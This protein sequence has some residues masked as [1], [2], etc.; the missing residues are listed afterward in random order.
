MKF[1]KKIW[2]KFRG[3]FIKRPPSTGKIISEE[4]AVLERPVNTTEIFTQIAESE[5]E[6]E[7]AS[8]FSLIA[9]QKTAENIIEFVEQGGKTITVNKIGKKRLYEL[10]ELRAELQ[11]LEEKRAVLEYAESKILFADYPDTLF[12]ERRVDSL[13]TLFYKNKS[14]DK[15]ELSKISI[16][17]FDK[18]F[19]KLEKLLNDKSTLRRHAT[20]ENVKQKQEEIYKNQVKKKLS[21][22]ENFINQ[23]KLVEA[24]T[25]IK[26]LSNSINPNLQNELARLTKAKEIYKEKEFYNYK[27]QEE[28]LLRQQTEKVRIIKELQEQKKNEE[29]FEKRKLIENQTDY[30]IQLQFDKNDFSCN[31]ILKHRKQNNLHENLERGVALLNGDKELEQY[32][33]S[34][35]NMHIAK[36]KSAFQFLIT[37]NNFRHSTEQIEIFDWGCGQGLGSIALIDQLKIHKSKNGLIDKITLIEPGTDALKRAA[38]HASL[39]LKS[40]SKINPINK[41]IDTTLNDKD[42]TNKKHSIKIHIFSNIIDVNEVD[43]DLINELITGKMSG[44]NYIVCV[45]PRFGD[46][47]DRKMKYFAD[48]FKYCNDF[49]IISNREDGQGWNHHKTWTRKEII[50]KIN[51]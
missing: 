6:N 49:K 31:T 27:K 36:L 33:Y 26:L 10:Y 13:T 48:S 46:S 12:I 1:L 9:K 43:A 17:A 45:G 7:R 23:N 50:L 2:R 24:K 47:K 4:K 21:T 5:N 16:S 11:I 51:L 29:A 18:S 37:P 25:L 39:A 35:G 41:Y 44:V 3:I 40:E 15:V 22:L 20:R 38:L 28:E 42:L 32:I 8:L 14:D 30:S 19:Q 34:F